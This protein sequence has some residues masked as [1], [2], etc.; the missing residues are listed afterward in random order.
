L[1][2]LIVFRDTPSHSI[3]ALCSYLFSHPLAPK[4]Y[5]A[6]PDPKNCT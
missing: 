5:A 1:L 3:V 6:K 4:Q 2:E